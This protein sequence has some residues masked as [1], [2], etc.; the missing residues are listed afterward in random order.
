MGE[1]WVEITDLNHVDRPNIDEWDN[2]YGVWRKTTAHTNLMSLKDLKATHP[3]AK[4]RCKRKDL[5]TAVRYYKHK[6]GF[7]DSALFIKR[8][9][10]YWV[11]IKK[12]GQLSKNPPAAW[13]SFYEGV[14]NEG[15]YVEINQQEV[16]EEIAKIQAASKPVKTVISKITNTYL[17]RGKSYEVVEE[18]T[19]AFKVKSNA[20]KSYWFW[21][22]CF[23]SE[24]SAPDNTNVGASA[25]KKDEE[26]MKKETAI[27]VAT[28]VSKIVG[29]LTWRTLN[30][31]LIEPA[32]NVGRPIVKSVRYA[33]FLGTVATAIYGYNNPEVVKNAIK[34]CIPKITI[35]APEIMKG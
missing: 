3:K 21:A 24:V 17:E 23:E 9:G 10:D 12:D 30:Y 25:P 16:D 13:N 14:V 33:V 26:V 4:Y 29:N 19:G 31:W 35:E 22:D 20:P 1:D 5:P 34:S 18:T 2:G 27:K 32:A 15:T 7:G 11:I 28:T 6:T 8:T